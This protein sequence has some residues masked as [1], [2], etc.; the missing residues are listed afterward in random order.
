MP[1]RYLSDLISTPDKTLY[2]SLLLLL[3]ALALLARSTWLLLALP[4]LF[5][6][7]EFLAIRPEERYLARKFGDE[8]LRY[9]ESVRRWI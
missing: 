5:L 8:Y 3:G 6:L 1:T 7:L 9:R 2:L 4:M